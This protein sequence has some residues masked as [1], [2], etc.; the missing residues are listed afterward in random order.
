M[1]SIRTNPWIALGILIFLC[2]AVIAVAARQSRASTAL[3]AR[4]EKFLNDQ[5]SDWHDWNVPYH[6]EV[7]VAS[8]LSIIVPSC[9]NPSTETT[10]P[11]PGKFE[12]PPYSSL[13]PAVGLDAFLDRK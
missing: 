6:G 10:P 7:G 5:R 4:V 11:Q 12:K 9:V 1:R 13:L 3:D 2:A 8:R